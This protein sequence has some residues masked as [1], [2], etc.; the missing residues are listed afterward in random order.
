M[1]KC[2]FRSNQPPVLFEI[3][4]RLRCK[5]ATSLSS[6]EISHQYLSKCNLSLSGWAT[7]DN[8]VLVTEH[9]TF[10]RLRIDFVIGLADDDMRPNKTN[11]LLFSIAD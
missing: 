11:S 7:Y 9:C 6:R 4:H 2:V 10:R 3:T 1:A 5:P 8:F